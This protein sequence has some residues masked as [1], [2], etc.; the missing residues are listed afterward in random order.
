MAALRTLW[1]PHARAQSARG[2]STQLAHYKKRLE[3]LEAGL[4]LERK[5]ERLRVLTAGIAGLREPDW[6]DLQG[7]RTLREAA[8]AVQLEEALGEASRVFDR[9]AEALRPFRAREVDPFLRQLAAAIHDRDRSAYAEAY[10]RI[11][12]NHTLRKSLAR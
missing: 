10:Q 3:I 9:L 8:E 7:L 6:S 11:T 2:F 5:S 4:E 12:A 1:S